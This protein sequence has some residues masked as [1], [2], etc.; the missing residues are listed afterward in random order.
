MS[1][2]HLPLPQINEAEL[3]RLLSDGV[4]ESRSIEYKR[5]WRLNDNDDK[6]EFLADVA[7]F[8]NGD[9]G[10]LIYGIDAKD[11]IPVALVGLAGFAP[12]QEQLRVEQ[13][14]ASW[15]DPRLAG[16]S[17]KPVPLAAGNI[18]F[19]IRVPRSWSAPHMVTFNG[20]D[21]FFSRNS[22]GKYQLDVNQ[23]RDA[24]LQSARAADRIRD[25]RLER[26][27]RIAAREI[28]V[29]LNSGVVLVW[30]LLP[31]S[32]WPGFSYD[33]VMAI[34]GSHLRPMGNVRGWGPQY[35]FDGMMIASTS[36]QGVVD[37]Y[38]QMFR[39]GSLEAALIEPVVEGR[40]VI[41]P[42][43]EHTLREGFLMYRQAF[44]VLGIDPP[45]Y[46]ALSLLNVGGFTTFPASNP[47]ASLLSH[48]V[49]DRPH[50]L[51]PEVAVD[52]EA[53]SLDAIV[54]P[55]FDL[56]WNACGYDRS[57]SFEADGKWITH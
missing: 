50:L 57:P 11:G 25:F 45:Y 14:A 44:R 56:V 1:L 17:L 26:I 21:R 53:T 27:S 2:Q 43:F 54:R 15:I 19:I 38:V 20:Y 23:L 47:F 12:E 24:F 18:I 37:S 10:D 30:H 6:K 32:E 35:N 28:G 51:L 36:N 52:S 55:L 8:A 31:I 29:K 5:E 3:Q 42:A 33:K 13:L 4:R 48:G 22:A 46:V 39:N 34:Q 16:L 40:K 41:Y 7:S 9:G 49:I